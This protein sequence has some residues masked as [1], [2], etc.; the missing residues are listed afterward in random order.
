MRTQAKT[1]RMPI[2]C[3][4]SGPKAGAAHAYAGRPMDDGVDG[5]VGVGRLGVRGKQIALHSENGCAKVVDTE[6]QQGGWLGERAGGGWMGGG[7]SGRMGGCAG[8]RPTF[9]SWNPGDALHEPRAKLRASGRS[10]RRQGRAKGRGCVYRLDKLWLEAVRLSTSCSAGHNAAC[11]VQ[12]SL[13]HIAPTRRIT[14]KEGQAL[15]PELDVR[16]PLRRSW[17]GRL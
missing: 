16:R 3:C 11:I 15:P 7:A 13:R 8:R 6:A 1:Q 4:A 12:L 10:R 5:S 17:P 2:A 14:G 9:L